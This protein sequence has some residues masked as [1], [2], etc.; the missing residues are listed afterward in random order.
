MNF[1]KWLKRLGIG[2]VYEISSFIDGEPGFAANSEDY[3]VPMIYEGLLAAF[4]ELSQKPSFQRMTR[5]AVMVNLR[6]IVSSIKI[7][8]PDIN[9]K[10]SDIIDVMINRGSCARYNFSP[11]SIDY[12]LESEEFSEVVENHYFLSGKIQKLAD[13]WGAEIFACPI[14]NYPVNSFCFAEGDDPLEKH[15]A[16]LDLSMGELVE[17]LNLVN[18]DLRNICDM[19]ECAKKFSKLTPRY[20]MREAW[21]S[22]TATFRLLGGFRTYTGFHDTCLGVNKIMRR[23][24]RGSDLETYLTNL[25][26][27]IEGIIARV[28]P[29]RLINWSFEALVL[30]L[31]ADGS[32]DAENPADESDCDSMI[33]A[34]PLRRDVPRCEPTRGS[35]R[36][37]R[38]ETCARS[39][40][41]P[42]RLRFDTM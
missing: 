27:G 13:E 18:S 33:I 29:V 23:K 6:E 1:N 7:F 24:T 19:L 25:I 39:L 3:S 9:Q 14:Q 26:I 20:A 34:L 21:E 8:T 42:K 5:S 4:D 32:F 16:R 11:F 15:A 36:P 38:P 30:S 40:P 12:S 41:K 31:E 10:I 28:D 2:G 35:D 22:V 37:G 17:K